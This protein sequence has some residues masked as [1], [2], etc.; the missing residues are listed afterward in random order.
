MELTN[1][2]FDISFSSI[3]ASIL[4][5]IIGL[6]MYRQGKKNQNYPWLFISAALM[7]YTYITNNPLQ[8]WGIGTVL[9]FVAYYFR[10]A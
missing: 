6:W 4:F 9:C 1:L 3:A 5:S 8:D 2:D 10:K 7:L